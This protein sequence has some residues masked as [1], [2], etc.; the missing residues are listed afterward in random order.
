MTLESLA[1]G[2]RG[3]DNGGGGHA[4]ASPTVPPNCPYC[5]T[6]IERH[7]AWQCVPTTPSARSDP[8]SAEPVAEPWI[9]SPEARVT[10]AVWGV[11]GIALAVIGGFAYSITRAVPAACSYRFVHA[12]GSRGC[13]QYTTVHDLAGAGIVGG[14]VLAAVGLLRVRRR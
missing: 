1:L 3:D 6:P 5:G 13:D 9:R 11:V 8:G 12:F 10:A 14:V 4:M 2:S 7:Q